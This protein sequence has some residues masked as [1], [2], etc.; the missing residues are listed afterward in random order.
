MGK[1]IK[2]LLIHYLSQMRKLNYSRTSELRGKVPKP[3]KL[4]VSYVSLSKEKVQAAS[5]EILAEYSKTKDWSFLRPEFR[6]SR[7]AIATGLHRQTFV[8]SLKSPESISMVLRILQKRGGNKASEE[9]QERR[10]KRHEK[11]P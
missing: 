2:Y 5:N 3:R 1:K 10:P 9:S 6:K 8:T 11:S 4:N 7:G